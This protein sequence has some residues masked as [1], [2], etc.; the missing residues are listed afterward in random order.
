MVSD[1]LNFYI[2]EISEKKV[3]LQFPHLKLSFYWLIKSKVISVHY[4]R[5]III[6]EIRP[7]S[8]SQICQLIIFS[9]MI[10][11]LCCVHRYIIILSLLHTFCAPTSLHTNILHYTV[12][13]ILC[14]YE[15]SKLL[16]KLIWLKSIMLRKWLIHI[17]FYLYRISSSRCVLYSWKLV[18]S[19]CC[20]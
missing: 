16:T 17:L 3:Y 9:Y 18:S 15:Y 8:I 19:V 11:M 1:F 13:T 12:P 20:T 7:Y 2:T 14:R 5:K 6:S 10:I 4:Y